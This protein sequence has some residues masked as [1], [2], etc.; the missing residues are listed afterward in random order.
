MYD[1]CEIMH[2]LCKIMYELCEIMYELWDNVWN[3]WDNAW[4]MWNNVWIM[5]DNVWFMWDNVWFM[6]DNVWF[7]WDNAWT[8]WDTTQ[9]R[10]CLRHYVNSEI[11]LKW[12]YTVGTV[13][14]CMNND[15]NIGLGKNYRLS[16]HVKSVRNFSEW[17]TLICQ[18]RTICNSVQTVFV[19][20]SIQSAE[21]VSL[22][23]I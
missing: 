5:W 13:W 14:S 2:E 10:A 16:V 4:T 8:M 23:I 15:N 21:I 1:L 18:G 11:S 17:P 12:S 7:M 20:L 19:F 3:M 9:C 22:Y 6:W